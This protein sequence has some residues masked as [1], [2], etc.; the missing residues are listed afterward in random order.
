MGLRKG[1][2]FEALILSEKG[3]NSFKE[4]YCDKIVFRKVFL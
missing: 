4:E 1:F 2:N 3:R